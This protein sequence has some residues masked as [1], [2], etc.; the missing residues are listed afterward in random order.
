MM[1]LQR[2]NPTKRFV[3][4]IENKKRVGRGYFIRGILCGKGTRL[5]SNKISIAQRLRNKRRKY[6]RIDT[7]V[8]K[9]KFMEDFSSFF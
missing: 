7:K 3:Y 6:A 9:V 2:R 5:C 1:R 4:G 8:N